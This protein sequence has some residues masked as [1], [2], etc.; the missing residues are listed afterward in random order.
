ML[1]VHV[2]FPS[3]KAASDDDSDSEIDSITI[4]PAPIWTSE[5]AMTEKPNTDS[6]EPIPLAPILSD[7]QKLGTESFLFTKNYLNCKRICRKVNDCH[8]FTFKNETK[9][10]SLKTGNLSSILINSYVHY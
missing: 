2:V 5:I 7:T 8:S 6:N 9:G 10:C 3:Q 4:P 1:H